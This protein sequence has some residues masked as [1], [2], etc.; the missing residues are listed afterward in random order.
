MYAF[1]QAL[2]LEPIAVSGDPVFFESVRVRGEYV[3]GGESITVSA[4]IEASVRTRCAKCLEDARFP[5]WADVREDFMR[6]LPED[7][8]DRYPLLGS[9]IDLIPMARDALILAL[10]IRALCKPDCMGL[11]PTCGA[12]RNTAPCTCH[13]GDERQ[14]PLSALGELLSTDEEV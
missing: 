4:H 2:A 12:N 11:C 7:D 6:D 8:V 14:N 3:G 1:D 9:E 13:E 10:P 5:L